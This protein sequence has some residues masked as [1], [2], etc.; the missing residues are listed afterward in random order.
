[1]FTDELLVEAEKLKYEQGL[2]WTEVAKLMAEKYECPLSRDALRNR[3][4]RRPRYKQVAEEVDDII[5]LHEGILKKLKSNEY[6]CEELADLFGTDIRVIE[7]IIVDLKN[8]GYTLREDRGRFHLSRSI[9]LSTHEYERD[10][11]GDRIIR[12]GV[13]GDTH[14]GS[15]YTQ[16]TLLHRMYDL[17]ELEGISVVYHTG[18]LIEGESMRPGHQYECYI[19]GADEYLDHVLKAYPEREGITTEFITG[20]HDHSLIKH[21]GYD[22]GRAVGRE[23]NDM[24]YL[25]RGFARI[26]LTPECMFELRHPAGGYAYAR[27]YPLQKIINAIPGGTKPKIMAVGHFHHG[28]YLPYRNIH[29]FTT[30]TF[31]AQ[32]EWARDKAMD[33]ELGGWIIEV[34][35][36]EDG[37]IRRFKNE[38]IQ[39]YNP[40]PDDYKNWI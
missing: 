25:G 28:M 10:W 11:R 38:H 31:Q 4:R 34:H 15:K 22:I 21:V 19:H 9:I 23:R 8:Q 12:F 29:A 36:S 16:L 17:F 24:R 1:M 30:S 13:L 40:I 18:D 6:S 37:T 39:F 32:N 7:A 2:S 26:R 33:A 14:L 20:N 3:L 5:D 35:V 27:S